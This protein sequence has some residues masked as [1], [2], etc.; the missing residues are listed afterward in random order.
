MGRRKTVKQIENELK[1]AK[2]RATYKPP[3]KEDGA[4]SRRFPRIAVAYKP[5]QV[6]D[7]TT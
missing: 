5:V 4:T 2:A 1:Y 3:D 6:G 7:P